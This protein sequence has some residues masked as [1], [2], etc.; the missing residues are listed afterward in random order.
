M[1][2]K[3]SA[4]QTGDQGARRTP[5][6]PERAAGVAAAAHVIGRHGGDHGVLRDLLYALD[7]L[8]D[9]DVAR[10]HTRHARRTVADSCPAI[11]ARLRQQVRDAFTDGRP[12]EEIAATIGRTVPVTNR[13]I[14]EAFTAPSDYIADPDARLVWMLAEAPEYVRRVA[15]GRGVAA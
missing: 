11:D 14:T 4:S 12:V 13:I 15:P 6:T 10:R 7:V 2:T 3:T 1:S 8:P 9:P 5:R